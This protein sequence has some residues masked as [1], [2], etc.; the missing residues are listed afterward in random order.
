MDFIPLTAPWPR[1]SD[2]PS[3]EIDATQ[4][5]A[6]TIYLGTNAGFLLGLEVA[7]DHGVCTLMNGPDNPNPHFYYAYTPDNA[8]AQITADAQILAGGPGIDAGMMC[9][10]SRAHMP[11]TRA[12]AVFR[13]ARLHN[14][15]GAQWLAFHPDPLCEPGFG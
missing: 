11:L 12:V 10:P 14:Y 8:T 7:G 4:D 5:S 13:A 15:S 1:H 6:S 3:A 9:H 2:M